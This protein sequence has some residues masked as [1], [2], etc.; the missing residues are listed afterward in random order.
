[1]ISLS[2]YAPTDKV[3]EA[4]AWLI[5]RDGS[6]PWFAHLSFN[7]PH[8]PYHLPPL[9]LLKSDARSLDPYSND[10]NDNPHPYFK[11]MLEAMD[12]EI[13]RLLGTLTEAQRENT[14]I[15]FLGDNGT[16][17]GVIQ[18]PFQRGRGKGTVYQ[19]GMNVPFIVTGP[20]I[21]GGRVN[22]ALLNTVDFYATFL[23]LAGI[24]V[25]GSVPDDRG[26]DS[27][28]FAPLLHDPDAAFA[29]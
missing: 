11:A 14:Y 27:I 8:S 19:G 16:S 21:E 4:V 5:E 18:P 29:A 15:I 23:A 9:E 1:M 6:R 13:G 10:V 20:G 25:Q 24:D 7:L 28:S 3:N 26:F 22:E 2:V 12:T 17:G